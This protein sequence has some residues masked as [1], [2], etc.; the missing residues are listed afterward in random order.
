MAF[1]SNSARS[2]FS[3]LSF[4]LICSAFSFTWTSIA[5][6]RSRSAYTRRRTMSHQI[7]QCTCKEVIQNEFFEYSTRKRCH[8]YRSILSVKIKCELGKTFQWIFQVQHRTRHLTYFCLGAA[9]D[10]YMLQHCLEWVIRVYTSKF[11][12]DSVVTYFM[13]VNVACNCSA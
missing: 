11:T 9:I 7:Q 12:P 8:L 5:F 4:C 10:M 2:L 6:C 1:C 13:T 3:F